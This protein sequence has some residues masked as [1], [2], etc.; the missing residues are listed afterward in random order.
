MTIAAAIAALT[1]TTPAWGSPHPALD[2]VHHWAFATQAENR[3]DYRPVAR[4]HWGPDR[5]VCD[6]GCRWHAAIQWR[7]RFLVAV[8]QRPL[9]SPSPKAYA[10]SVLP[11]GWSWS[12][13]DTLW[14][15]E[16]GWSPTAVNPS[17]G[18]CG[19]PQFVPCRE[20][21][22]PEGQVDAGIEYIQGRYGSSQAA[23]G[24]WYEHGYY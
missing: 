20:W 18:A 14:T 12:A 23:L 10:M 13:L 3:S 9:P 21:G 19:I 11:A 4:Y 2:A 8:R 17:S 22:D 15:Y 7:G 6:A 1:I 5:A 16:S 24:F